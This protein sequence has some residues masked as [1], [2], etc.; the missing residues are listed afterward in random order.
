MYPDLTQKL[1]QYLRLISRYPA[2]PQWAV[3]FN[4]CIRQ[5]LL[6]FNDAFDWGSISML[7]VML[8]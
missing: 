1:A 5:A 7:S 6:L 4:D 2:P 8:S 3:G